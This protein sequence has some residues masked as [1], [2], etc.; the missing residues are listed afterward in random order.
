MV[1]GWRAGHSR[2]FSAG[3]PV[4]CGVPISQPTYPPEDTH[5]PH[6]FT[7]HTHTHLAPHTL[8]H[9]HLHHTAHTPTPH[10]LPSAPFHTSACLPTCLARLS[11]SFFTSPPLHHHLSLLS[12]FSSQCLTHPPPPYARAH[13]TSQRT[14]CRHLGDRRAGRSPPALLSLPPPHSPSCPP[15]LLLLL[16][17]CLLTHFAAWRADHAPCTRT[18]PPLL[19]RMGQGLAGTATAVAAS[20]YTCASLTPSPLCTLCFACLPALYHLLPPG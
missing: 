12:S 15:T 14:T 8:L 6:T 17:L 1:A 7:P 10:W 13:T 19:A 16:L 4:M 9:T 11:L 18:A 2:A 3:A 5:L 20:I